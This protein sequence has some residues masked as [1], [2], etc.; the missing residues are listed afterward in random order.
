MRTQ[1]NFALI[2]SRRAVG[3]PNDRRDRIDR[4]ERTT[5]RS[6]RT[7]NESNVSNDSNDQNYWNGCDWVYVTRAFG[8]AYEQ[9]D[10]EVC[11]ACRSRIGSVL[12]RCVAS[13][14]TVAEPAHT[15]NSSPAE[16]RGQSE[17]A[18]TEDGGRQARLLWNLARTHG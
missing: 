18:G 13:A 12:G 10:R 16:R 9:D 2:A 3:S 6:E 14:R 15:R 17:G 5:E 8:S 4:S 7:P 1:K 11:A